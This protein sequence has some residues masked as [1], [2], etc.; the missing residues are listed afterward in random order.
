MIRVLRLMEYTY[1]T[2]E[3]AQRDMDRWMVPANGSKVVATRGTI[4][5]TI[6]T[7]LDHTP[8]EETPS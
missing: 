8:E 3:E 7:N 4:R 2:P 6:I 5:S 1:D